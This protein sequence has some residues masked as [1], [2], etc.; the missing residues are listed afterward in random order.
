LTAPTYDV[1]QLAGLLRRESSICT[2]CA[3]AKL[4]LSLERVIDAVVDLGRTVVIE[5]GL[6]RCPRCE[7]TQWVLA[8]VPVPGA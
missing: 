4:A 1:A 2:S 6:N 3:A 7:K 5:Q 8:V